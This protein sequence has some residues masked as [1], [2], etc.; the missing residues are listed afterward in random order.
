M[1]I[2]IGYVQQESS[3][4]T[5]AHSSFPRLKRVAAKVAVSLV[6]FLLSAILNTI[7]SLLFAGEAMLLASITPFIHQLPAIAP[8]IVVLTVIF[9]CLVYYLFGQFNLQVLS[10]LV[11]LKFRRAMLTPIFCGMTLVWSLYLIAGFASNDIN[12]I[13]FFVALFGVAVLGALRSKRKLERKLA[14]SPLDTVTDTFQVLLSITMQAKTVAEMENA[15]SDCLSHL[16]TVS[17]TP[18]DNI[19]ALID[20][21]VNLK[22]LAEASEVSS[23][24]LRLLDK[25]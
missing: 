8:T 14:S 7:V 2:Q 5:F 3:E 25:L 12:R 16:K 4:T 13:G 1:E 15:A 6:S 9:D 23:T 20:E 17:K 22:L 10:Q 19:A 11:P 18:D 21:L 24:Q